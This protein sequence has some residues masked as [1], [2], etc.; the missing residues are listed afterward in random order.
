MRQQYYLRQ[1][2]NG[3]IYHVIFVD[4][5]SNKQIDRTTGT[6][7]EKKANAIAQEWIA[8]GL[9]EK[10]R[11]STI[12]KTTTFC[13]YLVQFWDFEKSMYFR[14]LET[15][16]R[17]PQ[18][19]HAL[20]MQKLIERY[21]RSFFKTILLCQIDGESLQEFIVH[22][23]I[24]RGLASNTV[25]LARNAALVAL[26]Y[27]KRKKIIK[28][29]DFDAVLR[30]GGKPKERGVLENH[31]VE[32]LFKVKWSS[33]RARIA[34]LIALHT[35]MRLGEIR[36]L[37]VCDIHENKINVNYSWSKKNRLKCTKNR[38]M[39][40]IPIIPYLHNEIMAYIKQ[41]QLFNLDSL[42]L[43]GKN[44]EKPL[45]S[46][47]IREDYYKV[48]NEIGIDEKARKERGIVFHSWR[49]LLAKNLVEKGANKAIGMKIL[50]HKT[51]HIFDHYA[52]HVDKETFDQMTKVIEMV[53]KNE[54]PK[55]PIPFKVVI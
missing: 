8:N 23:K 7:D 19:E 51:S 30:A 34:V 55:E 44:P 26:K 27:A 43:P 28:Y 49:H 42:L 4:P 25:N 54:T 20:E 24:E 33:I 6:N 2:A 36:A 22:L 39:R 31:E 1:R 9:P 29:F 14:E 13:D 37:R 12:A 18:P 32:K 5:I 47:Q 41:M 53:S 11:T 16:G 45:D 50:G 21:Y 52:S 35:G 46:V 48:L 3:G 38:E 17:E 40:E 10:P 15:M